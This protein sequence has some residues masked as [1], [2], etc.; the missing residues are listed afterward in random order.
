MLFRS[1]PA[2]VAVFLSTFPGGRQTLDLDF[3]L[4]EAVE[5]PLPFRISGG[6]RP[7]E[8]SIDG[9]PDWVTLFPDQGILAG[10]APAV[11]TGKTFLCTFRVT[12]SEPVFGQRGAFLMA[13]GL[14]LVLLRPLSASPFRSRAR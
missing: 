9:C 14:W 5:H 8:S 3:P 1:L 7:Y 2:A 10:T 4:E 6:I 13:S 12:E 11:D